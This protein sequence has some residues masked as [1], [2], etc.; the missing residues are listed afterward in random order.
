[1]TSANGN[2]DQAEISK[3]DQR[4]ANWWNRQGDFK[5]LHDINPLRLGYIEAR[6]TLADAMVLDVGCGGGILSE[7]IAKRGAT[8]TGIDLAEAPLEVARSHSGQSGLEIDYLR[9]SAEEFA[10]EKAGSF[11]VITCM[12][13]LEHVPEP[14]VTIGA[15]CKLL[16]QGG[17]L[18]L[19]SVN[20]NPKSYLLAIVAAEYILNLVPRGTHDYDRLIQPAE[21]A[22]WLRSTGL[23]I[24][25]ITGMTYNPIT[26]RY[27]LTR[28]SDVNYLVHATR[29]G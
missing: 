7:G 23:Q 12:E 17:H 9:L 10:E 11:D 1:M 26:Q 20:R 21:L 4:A 5:A 29:S 18:F 6:A 3:F 19:S 2:V 16:K 28:N 24:E 13:L 25:E 22:S 8:V 15:C 27:R 14:Q